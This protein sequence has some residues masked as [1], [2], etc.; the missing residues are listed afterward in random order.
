MV[1]YQAIVVYPGENASS[2]NIQAALMDAIHVKTHPPGE[3]DL[4]V[5]RFQNRFQV[6]SGNLT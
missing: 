2:R 1:I 5:D 6:P 4:A 3:A